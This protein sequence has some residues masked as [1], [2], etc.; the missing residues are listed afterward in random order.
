MDGKLWLPG[1]KNNITSAKLWVNGEQL[2]L[3]TSRDGNWAELIL[4]AKR[5]ENLISII[6][7]E[8]DGR[9]EVDTSSSLDPIFA[10]VLPVD[11]ATAEGV[12]I[13]EKRWMEKFGEWKHIEQAQDWT[14]KG[15]VTWKVVVK[16]PGYYQTE[17]NYAGSGRLV[18]NITSDE[19]NVVQNQQNSSEVY[20]YYEM[21]LLKFERPGEHTITVSLVDGNRKGAS[22]KEIR[23]TPEESME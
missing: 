10:T 8:L 20:N 12:A 4:P 11:F 14:D 5:P 22:L 6:E 21:G 9:P 18:W 3:E 13:S 23:L 7:V 17:L 2:K 1:L 15:K 16:E 19:G